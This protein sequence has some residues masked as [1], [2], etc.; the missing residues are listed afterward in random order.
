MNPERD[1]ELLALMQTNP[2]QAVTGLIA[3]YGGLLAYL[4]RQKGLNDADTTEVL[5]DV[6]IHCSRRLTD[7]NPDKGTLVS[8]LSC[9]AR[10]KA[11][12]I[13][14][15]NSAYQ[16]A[17]DGAEGQQA[18]RDQQRLNDIDDQQMED[19]DR[20]R[21]LLSAMDHLPESQRLVVEAMFL[22]GM[23]QREVAEHLRVPLGT[24]KTR[25]ELGLTKLRSMI[26]PA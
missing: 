21:I 3:D 9:M 10:R 17:M 25:M 7:Y 16:R 20:S 8:W 1:M 19:S 11:I 26:R 4:I 22:K 24:I 5:Q 12:D 14:R 6:W 18:Q 2:Q 15:R 23:S 13:I